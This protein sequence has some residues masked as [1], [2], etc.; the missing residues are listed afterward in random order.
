MS[1][2]NKN[3][4]YQMCRSL[5]KQ[6][7]LGRSKRAA[8]KNASLNGKNRSEYIHSACT[9][10]TYMQHAKEYGDFLKEK[11]MS[12]CTMEEAKNHASEYILKFTS[13][14]SQHTAR[15]ALAR[16]FNC[17]ANDLCETDKRK[18]KNIIRGRNFTERATKIE[19]K[20]TDLVAIAKGTGARRSEL[21]NLCR[22]DIFEKENEMYIHI[23]GKG[24]RQRDVLIYDENVKKLLYDRINRS[25]NENERSDKPLYH[26]PSHMN[27]HAYRASYARNTYQKVMNEGKGSGE[28]YNSRNF[29]SYDKSALDYVA[30]QMGHGLGRYYTTV[31]N[32]LS[33]GK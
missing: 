13:A 30:N 14:H 6:V 17:N 22:D 32:Y 33:Y 18:G 29:G 2:N 3:I 26:V 10:R 27:I 24:G 9:I 12:Y 4:R 5:E 28:L 20:Y 15:S 21:S 31:T 23:K 11:G 19:N 8:E 16:I 1:K 25:I 7:G